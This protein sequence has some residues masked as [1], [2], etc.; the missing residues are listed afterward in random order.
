MQ[1]NCYVYGACLSFERVRRHH[2]DHVQARKILGPSPGC[3]P[4]HRFCMA[5]R[6]TSRP[7]AT[8]FRRVRRVGCPRCHI[9]QRFGWFCHRIVVAPMRSMNVPCCFDRTAKWHV[10][11]QRACNNLQSDCELLP[12]VLQRFSSETR[13]ST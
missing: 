11:R 8:S 4:C 2:G 13:M 7:R 6:S 5:R 9:A 1:T 3:R 12:F 10:T